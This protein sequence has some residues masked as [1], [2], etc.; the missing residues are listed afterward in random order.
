L[1]TQSY[2]QALVQ[3]PL[4]TSSQEM[5]SVYSVTQNTHTQAYILT[6]LRLT[7]ADYLPS[8]VQGNHKVVRKSPPDLK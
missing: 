3:L 1:Y 8:S 2:N 6:C 7:S 5:E 4:T